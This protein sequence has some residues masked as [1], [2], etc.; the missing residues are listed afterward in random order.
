MALFCTKIGIKVLEVK[1]F[2]LFEIAKVD[3]TKQRLRACLKIIEKQI[4]I[5]L[6]LFPNP[7]GRKKASKI[8][9]KLHPLGLGKLILMKFKQALNYKS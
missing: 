2:S 6:F 3:L 5:N 9:S 1:L 8:S 4:F 7:K